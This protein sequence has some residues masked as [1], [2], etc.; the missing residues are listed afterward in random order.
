[1][2]YAIAILAIW[3]VIDGF[4]ITPADREAR[5]MATLGSLLLL[6]LFV[7]AAFLGRRMRIG[8]VIRSTLGWTAV[9][10]IVA[11]AFTYRGE[12]AQVGG[13]VLSAFAP[14]L[15]I[16]GRLVGDSNIASVMV[17]RGRNGQFAVR[18]HVNDVPLTM[19][20]DT[21]ASFVTLTMA[22][23]AG[24]GLDIQALAFTVPIRTANG[25]IRAA[26][27]TLDRLV[28]G[29]IERDRVSALVAPP[30]SL[31]ESL[32]GMSFLETL[33]GYSISGDQ[34]RLDN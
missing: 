22:D 11:A 8:E 29:A 1:L 34:M 14:G 32:L 18:T 12:L 17:I 19:L 26:P 15:P 31:S 27:I 4:W 13:R 6:V 33:G 20:V 10:L 24:I 5:E 9:F 28:V 3:L 2:F 21:G 16:A 30:D 23:A 25:Q 7:G